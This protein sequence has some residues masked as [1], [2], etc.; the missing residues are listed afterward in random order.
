[1]SKDTRK[2]VPIAKTL[3]VQNFLQGQKNPMTVDEITAAMAEEFGLVEDFKARESSYTQGIRRECER[4]VSENMA[5]KV[6]QGRKVVYSILTPE[7]AEA[8]AEAQAKIQAK[9][10][11]IAD[12]L[13]KIG[14]TSEDV[15][16][17]MDEHS[18]RMSLDQCIHVLDN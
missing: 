9:Q 8:K 3:K 17:I 18:I 11:Q 15:Q 12:S 4:L 16:G 5:D 1:M 7:Q 13:G 2:V 10:A 6:R 14:F